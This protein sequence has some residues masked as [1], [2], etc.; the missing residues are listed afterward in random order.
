MKHL[1]LLINPESGPKL[2][3]DLRV[4]ILLGGHEVQKAPLSELINQCIDLGMFM[5]TKRLQ[6][7]CL[8]LHMWRSG[9]MNPILQ[10]NEDVVVM[11]EL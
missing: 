3:K 7:R 5:L 6:R 10:A 1:A 2:I 8:V 4:P 9:T 11:M